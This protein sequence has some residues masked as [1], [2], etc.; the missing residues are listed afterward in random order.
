MGGE[1]IPKYEHPQSMASGGLIG[2][3]AKSAMMPGNI[4]MEA[5]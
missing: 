3:E 4:T 5:S 1:T 2:L